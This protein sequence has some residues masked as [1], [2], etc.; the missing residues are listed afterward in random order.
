MPT[1][2]CSCE[3]KDVTFK[4]LRALKGYDSTSR[5]YKLR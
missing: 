3:F 2:Q 1:T 5:L 4:N